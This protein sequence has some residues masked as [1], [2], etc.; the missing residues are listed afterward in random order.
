MK[1]LDI[2]EFYSEDGG[3]VRTYVEQKFVAARLHGHSVVVIAPGGEDRVQ[4]TDGGKIIWVKAPVLPFD[5]RYHVFW[6]R[7]AIDDIVAAEKPDLIE[8]SSPWRGG[9][10]AARQPAM[11]PK[12]MV[13]HQDPVLSYP[14]M[15]FATTFAP[16]SIDRKFSWFYRSYAR[17]QAHYDLTIVSSD[18]LADRLM[19][20]G[21]RRPTPVRFGV[22]VARFIRARPSAAMRARMLAACG[23]VDPGATLFLSVCRLHPE[24]RVSLMLK[25]FE[26]ASKR[27]PMALF[28]AG[29]GP[30]RK[31]M[32]ALAQ[33]IPGV[34]LAGPVRD[35]DELATMFASA[36]AYAHACPNETFGMTVAEA[37][38]AGLP[39]VAA[40]EGGAG[41]LA[42][43]EFS[44]RFASND[45]DAMADALV[46]MC[47]R[48]AAWRQKAGAAA[49]AEA[50]STADHFRRL[51]SAYEHLVDVRRARS[52]PDAG[53]VEE[54]ATSLE[55]VA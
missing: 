39:L 52:L 45:V 51:F 38:A 27:A 53:A 18:W 11:I 54:A 23:V 29:D 31:V 10:I 30:R 7:K 6:S 36:D 50:P 55:K 4:K 28:H 44:E 37:M 22:E 21:M 40:D 17:M 47:A 46:R 48:D 5:H 24:K 3:G 26:I 42:R 16:E 32:Q 19:A 8:G 35:R 41:E 13:V 15:L 1:I 9:W 25:A 2:S 34:H 20:Q 14:H 12:A 43:P 49:R 33:T